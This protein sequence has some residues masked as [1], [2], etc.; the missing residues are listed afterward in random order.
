MSSLPPLCHLHNSSPTSCRGVSWSWTALEVSLNTALNCYST[1][2]LDLPM[3]SFPSP[4][5]QSTH[6]APPSS[7]HSPQS[8]TVQ[9]AALCQCLPNSENEGMNQRRASN[10]N[11]WGQTCPVT[12]K[13]A[14]S[15]G[16]GQ[17]MWRYF[18]FTWKR[19]YLPKLSSYF[20]LSHYEFLVW[21]SQKSPRPWYHYN[22]GQD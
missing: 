1:P 18:Y 12:P 7:F 15:L 19:K 13:H 14:L 4:V 5:A 16:K 17:N 22:S 10:L 21:R 2:A 3:M 9:A 11:R 8:C 6:S 20:A